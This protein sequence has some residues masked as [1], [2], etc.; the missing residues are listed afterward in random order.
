MV[1]LK[2]NDSGFRGYG[3]SSLY[4]GMSTGV[5]QTLDTVPEPEEAQHY[6]NIETPAPPA[7][8]AG[9]ARTMWIALVAVIV[10]IVL[11]G[12]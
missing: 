8:D 4:P 10:L 9:K 7:V 11:F 5:T 3:L 6:A 12:R 1:G 2:D